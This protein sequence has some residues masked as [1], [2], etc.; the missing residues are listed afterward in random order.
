M[1]VVGEE[2]LCAAALLLLELDGGEAGAFLARV[3]GG[4]GGSQCAPAEWGVMDSRN[5][6]CIN[7]GR[8]GPDASDGRGACQHVGHVLRHLR[9]LASG[10][11]IPGCS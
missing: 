4:S 5:A 9:H 10:T 6:E 1:L 11:V 8:G 2:S 7:R 3:A